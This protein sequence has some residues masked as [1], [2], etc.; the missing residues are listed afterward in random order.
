MKYENGLTN[1]TN[2]A[3]L[4]LTE[5]KARLILPRNQRPTVGAVF[6]NPRMS[7]N[8][9]LAILFASSFF[10]K[11]EHLG[12]CDPMTGCGVRAVRY[13]LEA[14]TVGD[15]IAADTN[16]QAV[17]TA[18]GIVRLNGL[19]DRITLIESDANQ[20]LIAHSRERFGLIDLDPF[21]TP[22]PF[23]ESAARATADGGVIAMTAT[24]MGPLTGAKPDAC[25]RKYGSR[26]IRTEFEKEFATRVL[27]GTLASAAMRLELGIEIVF[28]HAT[29]HYTRIYAEIHKGRPYANATARAIGFVEYCPN[30][31]TRETR[32]S[33]ELVQATCRACG[34]KIIVGGP[35]WI[36]QLWDERAVRLMLG[37][38][39]L[40]LS[41]RLSEVQ[42]LLEHVHEEMRRPM[43]YF[44]TDVLAGKLQIKPPK[45]SQVLDSL[46]SK[47]YEA[48]RTHFHPN[49]FRTE[50]S[51]KEIASIL[52]ALAKKA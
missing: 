29:D 47:G 24:D 17:E 52:R 35:L 37:R 31:L 21:G 25:W 3:A 46:S 26:S 16:S 51:T 15:V 32:K 1:Q 13:V 2:Q 30:C 36:G 48:S 40:L 14:P 50:A 28:C 38:V 9:D 11:E 7:L 6:Y 18:K 23:A 39:P 19:E 49:G 45:L 43:L 34:S 20:L 33:L 41:S 22:A 5:G 8:R 10:P 12:V 4:Q 42:A 27:A 44:R